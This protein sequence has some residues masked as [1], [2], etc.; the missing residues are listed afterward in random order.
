MMKKAILMALL[1][2]LGAN[3]PTFAQQSPI[4]KYTRKKIGIGLVAGALIF[5]PFFG[6]ALTAIDPDWLESEPALITCC[7]VG[8]VALYTGVFMWVSAER[9]IRKWETK[10]T[11]LLFAIQG[12]YL[13]GSNSIAGASLVYR[14]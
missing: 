1:L 14:Y 4:E 9:S 11:Q 6:S 7:I 10:K 5:L 8:S 2:T 3:S 12:P 13:A